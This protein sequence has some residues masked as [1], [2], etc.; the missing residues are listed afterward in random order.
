MTMC[1][2]TVLGEVFANRVFDIP[3]CNVAL[4]TQLSLLRGLPSALLGAPDEQGLHVYLDKDTQAKSCSVSSYLQS[5][6]RDVIL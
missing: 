5:L 2:C 4:H 1:H 6:E 3:P